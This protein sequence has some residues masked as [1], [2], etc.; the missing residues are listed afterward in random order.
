MSIEQASPASISRRS[1]PFALT[2]PSSIPHHVEAELLR[3]SER[4]R[5]ITLIHPSAGV[6]H[7]GGSEVMAIEL[8]N[9]LQ[10]YFHVTLLSGA[11]CGEFS[12]PMR[13]IQRTRAAKWMQKRWLNRL[14]RKLGHHPEIVIEHATSFVPTLTTLLR[15]KTQLIFP[16]N[17]YGGLAAASVARALKGTPI[18]FTEHLGMNAD[19]KCL[20]RN[21][22][23]SPDHLVVIDPASEA[24]ARS[25]NPN[26]SISLIPN[27]V[28][29]DRFTPNGPKIDF[30]LPGKTV[31]CVA[32]LNQ[33]S[34]K[35][36]E[37]AIE[38]VRRLPDASLVLCGGGVDRQLY[39][40]L[41]NAKLGRDR[42]KIVQFPHAQMPQVY[43]SVDAFTLPSKFEAFGLSYV[44]AMASGLPVVGTDDPIRRYVIGEGGVTCDVTDLDQYTDSL[45]QVL[46]VDWSDRARHSARRF[47]WDSIILQYRDAIE[48]TLQVANR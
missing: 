41:C 5:H 2:P 21:L 22:K 30:G 25:I 33:Q 1:T 6:N 31:L 42:F 12:Q 14:L 20:A 38:A 15:S 34:T 48:T 36:V 43:R 26:Q 40:D 9:R 18:L 28:D 44:E 3:R 29:L 24:F 45:K 23:F 35:R 37:L 19:G 16:Q 10:S 8:A 7:T 47:N 32:T 17:D 39:E 4:R 27:G 46:S 13:V 11:D